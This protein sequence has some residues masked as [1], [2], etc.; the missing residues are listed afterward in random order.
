MSKKFY[1]E[2]E[3]D[4]RECSGFEDSYGWLNY[5]TIVAEGDTLEE[6]L[7]NATIF[8]MDQDGGSGPEIE[9]DKPW[10]Q[11]LIIDAF[12]T[13]ILKQKGA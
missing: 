12:L 7:E 5:D 11:D 4:G 10:M 9:A 13:K 2:I 3:T 1:L 6:C 8:T